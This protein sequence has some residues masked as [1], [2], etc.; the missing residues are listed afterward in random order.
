MKTTQTVL[1]PKILGF[2]TRCIREAQNMSQDALAVSSG[3]DVRTIQRIEA[4]NRVSIGTKRSL[5]R[6]LGYE[7]RDIFDDPEFALNVHNFLE[8]AQAVTQ[9][10]LEKQHPDHVRVNAE[11]VQSGTALGRLAGQANALSL[12]ADDD[13]SQGAKGVAAALFDYI[14][15]LVDAGDDVSYSDKLEFDE[16]MEEMLRELEDLGTIAYSAFRHVKVT[17]DNWADKTPL[18]M[19]IGYLAIVPAGRTLST[20][21]VPRRLR[22]S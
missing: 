9:E 11:R 19:T 8:G 22:F 16:S 6:G 21:F 17:G 5:A 20:M 13:I 10:S 2:W 14:R 18:Q 7:N 3:L 12:T 4:G 15:D 1:E